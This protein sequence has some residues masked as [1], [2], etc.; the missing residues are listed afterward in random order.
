MVLNSGKIE[1]ISASICFHS[2]MDIGFDSH[3]LSCNKEKETDF[4]KAASRSLRI[5]ACY[6][7]PS[8]AALNFSFCSHSSFSNSDLDRVT[9]RS[10]C[11]TSP[12]S[13]IILLILLSLFSLY[14]SSNLCTT[15]ICSL[16]RCRSVS[17]LTLRTISTMMIMEKRTA[18]AQKTIRWLRFS[19]F[20]C[21]F[22]LSRMP[23]TK[24]IIVKRICVCHGP[25]CIQP[26]Y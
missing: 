11:L 18:T 20:N 12:N 5:S 19:T 21:K 23:I 22:C 13:A 7:L 17:D 16:S 2:E 4:N 26:Y 24:L 14:S 6:R 25:P 3:T 8:M 10:S 9:S 15:K 1:S